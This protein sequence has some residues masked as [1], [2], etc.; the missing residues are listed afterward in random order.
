MSSSQDQDSTSPLYRYAVLA[1]VF[2]FL[3]VFVTVYV[4]SKLETRRRDDA[5]RASVMARA[6]Q[7]AFDP[8]MKPP[9]FDA[10]LAEVSQRPDAP[11]ARDWEEMMPLSASNVCARYPSLAEKAGG[12]DIAPPPASADPTRILVNILVRMPLPTVDP[13]AST[14]EDDETPPYL[15][16]GQLATDVQ[17]ADPKG[18]PKTLKRE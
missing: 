6:G 2:L 14:A 17:H 4:R 13:G 16:I 10:Y 9:L 7:P 12:A 1:A 11:A 3:S 18:P 8:L 5:L 15:D